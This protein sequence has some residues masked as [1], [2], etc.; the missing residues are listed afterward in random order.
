M[1]SLYVTKRD[2]WDLAYYHPHFPEHLKMRKTRI[3]PDPALFA[4]YD[5]RI[6]TFVGMVKSKL[7]KHLKH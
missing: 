5:E 2:W 6:D 3:L 7:E 4:K 1:F